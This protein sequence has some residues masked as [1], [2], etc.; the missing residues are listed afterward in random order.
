MLS[1]TSDFRTRTVRTPYQWRQHSA[2]ILNTNYFRRHTG[3]TAYYPFKAFYKEFIWLYNVLF[4]D[5]PN[6][7]S[8]EHQQIASQNL[9]R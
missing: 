8:E 5:R 4:P 7:G 6:Q 2:A 3:G 9:H 1:Q